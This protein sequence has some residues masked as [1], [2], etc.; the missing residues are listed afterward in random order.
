[1][2]KFSDFCRF[3]NNLLHGIF[4][5]ME[6]ELL[7]DDFN[8]CNILFTASFFARVALLAHRKRNAQGSS[9]RK[10]LHYPA[11]KFASAIGIFVSA[12]P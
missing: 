12:K 11:Y 7:C 3:C 10:T 9:V 8:N 2:E 4:D 1:M 5:W 6:V